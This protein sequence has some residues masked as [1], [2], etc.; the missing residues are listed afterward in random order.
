MKT[1]GDLLMKSAMQFQDLAP[2]YLADLRPA[3]KCNFM[4]NTSR[5]Q[6]RS[7]L[8]YAVP[9]WFYFCP[10]ISIS[11]IAAGLQSIFMLL[12]W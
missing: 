8:F 3:M 7:V 1:E 12:V 9:C 2:A 11:V 6:R 5:D 4:C 10:H